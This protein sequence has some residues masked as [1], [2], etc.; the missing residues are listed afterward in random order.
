MPKVRRV[1]GRTYF[2]S[3][4]K[5]EKK[6]NPAKLANPKARA[7]REHELKVLGLV[8]KARGKIVRR[9]NSKD[10][11]I[12]VAAT[13]DAISPVLTELIKMHYKPRAII[14][15]ILGPVFP[16]EIFSAP[17][18]RKIWQLQ[19]RMKK[20]GWTVGRGKH[21]LWLTMDEK[22][23]EAKRLNAL[24]DRLAMLKEANPTWGTKQ[25]AK[26]LGMTPSQ[27]KELRD[28]FAESVSDPTKKALFSTGRP[29]RKR[30]LNFFSKEEKFFMVYEE[31]VGIVKQIVFGYA[32]RMRLS[33][34]DIDDFLADVQAKLIE[35]LDLF[36]PKRKIKAVTFIGNRAEGLAKHWIR[37]R[38]ARRRADSAQIEDEV[39][40]IN[41]NIREGR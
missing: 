37:E 22:I 11:E 36:D 8:E 14:S 32:K 33:S 10:D 5:P 13:M 31:H 26:E 40:A 41:R 21:Q 6:G 1:K 38:I 20:E 27:A 3:D 16:V 28:V 25:I 35:D 9:G 15:K 34:T 19:K 29:K 7:V 17:I 23:D 24:F 2:L 4:Y 18:Q 12:D 39:K 30:R